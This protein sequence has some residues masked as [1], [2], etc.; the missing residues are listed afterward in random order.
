M[1]ADREVCEQVTTKL[2]L[3]V[4]WD[5]NGTYMEGFGFQYRDQQVLVE[6]DDKDEIAG[7]APIAFHR[8]LGSL[9][10]AVQLGHPA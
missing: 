8:R 2:K 7:A 10:K 9:T 4:M 1:H 6:L 3:G 5:H